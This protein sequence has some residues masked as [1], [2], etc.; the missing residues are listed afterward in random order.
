MT[1]AVESMSF[2]G[3]TPW[4]G[5]GNNVTDLDI[6][7]PIAMAKAASANWTVSK[8]EMAFKGANGQWIPIKGDLALVRDTDES[9]LST[10]GTTWKEVQ[11]EQS[12]EFFTKWCKAGQM[13]P[14]TCGSLWGGRY[15]WMLARINKDFSIGKKDEI[16]P[17]LLLAS[18][19]VHGKA[20]LIQYTTVRVVC[21]NTLCMAIGSSLK[22]NGTGFRMPHS[23]AFNDAT[24]AKAEEALGLA[25]KQTT[26]FKEIVTKLSKKKM[27]VTDSE[28]YFCE[29][30]QFDPKKAEKKKGGEVMVPRMLPKFQAALTHA[31]GQELPS[32]LGTLWGSFNAITAVVDHQT[33]RND[34]STTLRNIWLG[35]M[36]GIKRRALEVAI[37]RAS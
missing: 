7:D 3:Q 18:P 14:E 8:R 30:L 31:P 28:E 4:H 26:E 1:D 33:G 17:Y 23:M 15:V 16:R 13:K 29:V 27:T 37:Q 11:N 35:H 22:G 21:W 20:L 12:F 19:H 36:A 34:R 9:H 6:D 25:V 5:L 24:K 32:A 2:S 10:V